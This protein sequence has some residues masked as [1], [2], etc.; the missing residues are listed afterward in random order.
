MG[1]LTAKKDQSLSDSDIRFLVPF[2][3]EPDIKK[4]PDIQPTGTG[5][6]VHPYLNMDVKIGTLHRK[7]LNAVYHGRPHFHQLGND[8]R[9]KLQ[10]KHI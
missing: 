1:E 8:V 6:P 4:R 9:L 3:P 2:W 7:Q 5:Y 10:I